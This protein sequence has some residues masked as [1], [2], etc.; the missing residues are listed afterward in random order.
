M[1]AIIMTK[2]G[3]KLTSL[4]RRRAIHEKCLNCSAWRVQQVTAC[5]KAKCSL[6][7]YRNGMGKHDSRARNKAIKEYCL[8]CMNRRKG[9]VTKCQSMHCPLYIFR[10]GRSSRAGNPAEFDEN[11]QI[12]GIFKKI[13]VQIHMCPFRPIKATKMRL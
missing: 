8:W 10:K 13:W 2:D 5:T 11:R 3:L 9:D 12:D 1:K 6:H 7:P 4:N